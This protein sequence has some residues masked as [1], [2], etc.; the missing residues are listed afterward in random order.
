MIG[1]NRV[2]VC[3]IECLLRH[4]MRGRISS[5]NKMVFNSN[6]STGKAVI[7]INLNFGGTW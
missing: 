3:I 6:I 5:N 7:Y 4:W 1:N 2:K